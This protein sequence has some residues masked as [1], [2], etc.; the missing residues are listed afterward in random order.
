MGNLDNTITFL[1]LLQ[2]FCIGNLGYILLQF[3]LCF[4]DMRNQGSLQPP[5]LYS[6]YNLSIRILVRMARFVL[7][8]SIFEVVQA[9]IVSL[10][11]YLTIQQFLTNRIIKILLKVTILD[12]F[13]LMCGSPS[14]LSLD[15][16]CFSS[17]SITFQMSSALKC[18]Y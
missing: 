10:D 16:H 18:L 3:V 1:L 9:V 6:C 5:I 2:R 13:S 15:L 8:I 14:A 4:Q 12:P 7:Q 11:D 17:S